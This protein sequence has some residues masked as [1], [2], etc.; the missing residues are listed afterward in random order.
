MVAR[1]A[2]LQQRLMEETSCSALVASK[3][4]TSFKIKQGFTIT[5]LRVINQ[6]WHPLQFKMYGFQTS[7]LFALQIV[8]L[9]INRL[10]TILVTGCVSGV[11][12]TAN[13]ATF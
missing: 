11:G 4:S 10:L 5:T 8:L 1:L 2:C 7:T 9:R 6:H 13:H 3:D 12:S